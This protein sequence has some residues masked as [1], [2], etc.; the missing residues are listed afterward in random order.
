[1]TN[2]T[3]LRDTPTAI[4]TNSFALAGH[5]FVSWN[6]KADGTGT[7]YGDGQT[8]TNLASTG[9]TITLYAVWVQGALLDT[10]INVN[11]KLKR[12]AGNS[13]AIYS[14]QD[15]AITA[16]VR[17]N[18]LPNGFT[19]ATEN[20][21]SDYTSPSPIYAWYDSSNT[22]IYYYSEA[23]NILMNKGSSSFFQNMRALSNLS[24]ISSWNTSK[25]TN[26]SFMFLNAGY[27]ATTFTLDL[28]SW[29]TSSVT[30]MGYM[31]YG[32]GYS[33]TSWSIGDLS[34]WNTSSVTNIDRKSV[35]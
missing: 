5:I 4:K 32:A 31:F 35:V 23:T 15:T 33:A 13:S 14:T 28:S 17:S 27:N 11:Q 16:I 10:G 3:V 34:S 8:V 24:T 9:N 6:T 29:N 1:M 2:Q 20:T 7:T 22:T 30:D 19:P 25:V 21:I 18:S 12:L 26:M